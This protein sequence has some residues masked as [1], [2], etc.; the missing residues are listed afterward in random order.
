MSLRSTGVGSSS[1][2]LSREGNRGYIY[3]SEVQRLYLRDEGGRAEKHALK[4]MFI[5]CAACRAVVG[6]QS[7]YDAGAL[8]KEAQDRLEKIEKTSKAA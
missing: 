4:Q 1:L 2:G 6:A 3:M 5:Q 8:A 7:Y